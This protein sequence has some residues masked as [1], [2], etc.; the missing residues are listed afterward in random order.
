MKASAT[1]LALF[2][3]GDTPLLHG[4]GA[5]GS[6]EGNRMKAQAASALLDPLD[7]GIDVRLQVV[8][9]LQLATQIKDELRTLRS[10]LVIVADLNVDHV[11]QLHR[12]IA[13]L[14]QRLDHLSHARGIVSS[15]SPAAAIRRRR[16]RPRHLIENALL[17][18]DDH[19]KDL[20]RVLDRPPR[21]TLHQWRVPAV[22]EP[23]AR[24]GAMTHL[25]PLRRRL[26]LGVSIEHREYPILRRARAPQP[27]SP[28]RSTPHTTAAPTVRHPVR[29]MHPQPTAHANRAT[30]A[31]LYVEIMIASHE[32]VVDLTIRDAKG[33][34]VWCIGVRAW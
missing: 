10:I 29:H 31:Y 25:E 16:H 5:A 33:K 19:V 32:L 8:G 24:G 15:T 6:V 26:D 13:P 20:L 4:K 14:R 17:D 11:H 22:I 27:R 28:P 7:D 34:Y 30:C 21:A 3:C 12:F 9:R 2:E 23:P 18:R 1:T